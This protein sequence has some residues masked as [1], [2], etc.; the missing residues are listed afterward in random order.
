MLILRINNMA[1]SL[2][3]VTLP[4]NTWVDLYNATGIS[5][6]AQLIIQNTG[7]DEARLSE[8]VA[9]PLSTTGYNNLLLNT[10]LASSSTPVGAWVMSRLGTTLQVEEL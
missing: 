8:S 9:E 6:G 7:K 5:V 10:Y 1:T 2:T 4:A 3:P